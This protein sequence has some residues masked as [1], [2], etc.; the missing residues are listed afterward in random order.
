[1]TDGDPSVA[2][3]SDSAEITRGVWGTTRDQPQEWD[4]LRRL[5]NIHIFFPISKWDEKSK[6]ET[7]L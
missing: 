2:R 7:F 1:M 6:S 5:F 3:V 4:E